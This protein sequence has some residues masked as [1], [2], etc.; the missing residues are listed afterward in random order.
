MVINVINPCKNVR[1][2]IQRGR[3]AEGGEERGWETGKVMERDRPREGKSKR[4]KGILI[5]RGSIFE[6]P[7]VFARD[8][9]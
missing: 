5:W 8:I 6:G 1:G 2:R 9:Y 7:E 4:D 3:S